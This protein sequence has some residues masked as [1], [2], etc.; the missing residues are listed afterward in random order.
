MTDLLGIGASGVRAYQAALSV[1]A[2]NVANA[3]TEN[4]SRRSLTLISAPIG[5]GTIFTR[6][7][8]SGGGVIAGV[9]SRAY[10]QLKTNAA[11]VAAGDHERL[12]AR[13][14]WLTRLQASVTGSALDAR[15]GGFF[16]AGVDLAA[17][18]TSAAAR[19]IFLDRADQTANSFV[20]LGSDLARIKGEIDTAVTATTTEINAITAG[21]VRI[22]D[23]M[24]RTQA[25]GAAVNGLLDNR[26]ALLA[27][28][29]ERLRVNVSAAANGTVTIRVGS[30][31]DGPVLVPD[32]GNAVR[33][34]VDT[35]G[36]ITQLVL[37][38]THSAVST[39]L[40]ASGS[41]AGLTEARREVAATQF[42]IDALATRFGDAVND[43]AQQGSDA[44]G[45]AGTPLFSTTMIA[46][47]TGVANA[48]SAGIET[49][50]ADGATPAP[51][52]YR[53]VRED[54]GWT[55][56]R[57][58]GTA[59]VSGPGPLL[60]DG[61]T[62][63]PGAGAKTGDNWRLD[64]VGGALGLALRPVGPQRLAVADR[65]VSDAAAGNKGDARLV[66]GPD[67]GATGF[68]GVPSLRITVT[69]F[70]A[71]SG[72]AEISDIATGTVV[73]TVALDGSRITGTGFG[74]SLVGTPQVGDS[75]RLLASGAGS[76]DNGNARALAQVR[77]AS[78]A[79]STLETS[80]DT[81]LA[82]IA[83]RLAETNRLAETA[84]AVR[85]D[86]ARA[87]DAVSGVD[88]NQEAAELT[89]LQAAYRANA[90][91]I[92]AA[93]DMLDTLFGIAR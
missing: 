70:A 34:G 1:T 61:L 5:A 56:A 45:D 28:L 31:S 43:W 50:L 59:S 62:V 12:A 47:T 76:N 65:Y 78:A 63:R 19:T 29:G 52:G 93:R 38:P 25:G 79:G 72:T 40:P 6:D 77:D 57:I 21:L 42:A 49:M 4:Y 92:A 58:D 91:V 67:A 55:L 36:D 71:G 14:D 27:A 10:D 30:G 22:N 15:L 68:A 20:S 64:P 80:L 90:Q 66:A 7:A 32:R 39:R 87:R 89:R 9:V 73:A 85:D 26:D 3:D 74:F 69:A 75:F 8:G 11:R 84:Q 17:A 83:S 48:G 16:D 82:G 18:P 60:L 33:V 41:L 51:D 53:L 44:L 46:I 86:S 24:R 2:D 81:S 54:S 13:S 88:I 35:S 23:E 37:D